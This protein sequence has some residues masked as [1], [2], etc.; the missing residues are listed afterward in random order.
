MASYSVED[1][2]N[3][4]LLGHAGS[5]KTSLAEAILHKTGITN[6][7]GSVDDKSSIMDADEEEKHRGH[8]IDSALAHIN[9]KGKEVNL[10]DTPGYPDFLGAALSAL[11][12]AETA[13][14]VVSASAGI[15]MN[16]R[17]LFQAARNRG[18]A[19]IIVVNKIDAGTDELEDLVKSIQENFGMECRCANLAAADGSTVIDC[20]NQDSGEGAF[21]DV[22]DAHT[23]LM[24]TVIEADE[25]LMEKYLGGEEIDTDKLAPVFTKAMISQMLVPI[26]FTSAR[27]EAG[28]ELLLELVAQ[29]APSPINGAKLKL[30][31]GSG[32]EQTTEE[33]APDS[34]GNLLGLVCRV[35][36]D[37][38]SHIKYT[39]IRLQRGIIKSDTSMQATGD[40]KG[41][42][43][44]Q[45]SKMQGDK[46]ESVDQAQAGDIVTLAKLEELRIRDT[47]FVGKEPGQIESP[48]VPIPMY[49]LAI[50]PKSRGDETK[51]SSVLTEIVDSDP[52]FAIDHDHQ[53]NETVV[54]GLGELHVRVILARMQS[55]RGL[56]VTTKSPKIPYRETISSSAKFVEYTHKKQSGGAGQFARVFIDMEPNETGAGY[57]FK[58]AIFGGSI[59]QPFRPSVDKG[60]RSA[61]VDG[62]VAG[63]PVVDVKVA[64]VDGK[65]HPVD[66]KDIAFQIAGREVFRKAFLLCSPTLL[67]PIVNMEVTVPNERVGDITGDLAGRRGRVQGQ[68]VLPGNMITIK[69]QVPLSE[70]QQYSSQLKSVTGG[71]GS[72]SM[73]LSHYESVPPNVMQQIIAKNK[74]AKQKDE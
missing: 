52:T 33:I 15:Q 51:I 69:A 53:T 54:S 41:M 7:L 55:H 72:Y 32:E 20:I 24:E 9:F 19:C 49:S 21:A 66:S 28:I 56:E 39:T 46:L 34:N 68:D 64:L 31:T 59:D 74:A 12:A 3:I 6:R 40:K 43:C 44:G 16:A 48:S 23:N 22:A 57:E 13:V 37:P 42:R 10:I 70:I 30:T 1:I 29:Y 65:T 38:K 25:E 26:V 35:S 8:S 47:I 18:M 4:I 62:V 14:I 73:E 60:C 27:N 45:I 67:E 63:Y 71:Q 36:S 61:M 50:E 11:P 2:R 58:D 17:K 5:G